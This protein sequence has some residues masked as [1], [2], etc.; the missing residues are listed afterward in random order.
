MFYFE[1]IELFMHTLDPLTAMQLT[2]GS[3]LNRPSAVIRELIDNAIDAQAQHI[4][5]YLDAQGTLAVHDDGIG[6]TADELVSAF[7]RHTTSKLTRYDDLQT[8]TTLGF[9]G[10]ALA[11][12]AAVARVICI[13]R[14]VQCTSAHEIRMA[15]GEMHDLRPCAGVVGTTIR[16]ERL[17]HTM[18]HRRHFWRQPQ[19]ERHHIV[20]VCTQ[21]ALI[22]PHIRMTVTYEQQVLL[23]TSGSGNHTQALSEVWPDTTTQAIHAGSS[24]DAG[25][26]HGFVGNQA[27]PA[28]RQQIV[29]IN[30]RPVAVKGFI[31]HLLDEVL[32]PVQGRHPT[33]LLHFRLPSDTIDINQRSHKDELGIRTP[34][35]IARLAYDAIRRPMPDV[36]GPIHLVQRVPEARFIGRHAEWCIW[37]S[38]EGI[39]IM[40]PANAMRW[41]GITSLKSGNVCVPPYPLNT[42]DA[43]V[44]M[45]YADQWEQLGIH[46]THNHYNQLCITRIPDTARTEAL[47]TAIQAC[48]R[49]MRRG[50]TLAM[51]LGYLVDPSW[52]YAQLA[53]H[54][55]PWDG[56]VLFMVGHQRIAH[57]LRTPL[58]T[59]VTLD[60]SQQS[61]GSTTPP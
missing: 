59:T 38:V 39:I 40:D 55:T 7:Q 44:F 43:Q 58:M 27:A 53:Q 8:L 56:H 16:V 26:L 10:E 57:A 49:T 12:I 30:H 52:L 45:Q 34:S 48:L 31:A 3:T 19:T 21:Y 25:E 2:A 13:S 11:A 28:R 6:M 17:Y 61:Q 35:I 60:Q 22:Y 33:A 37:S 47:D 15:A 29:A 46:L 42:Q 51:G 36:A 54:P 5:I 32:P 14:T 1:S 20:D 4:H 50:G 9:R 18:P 23:A 41:C 24:R